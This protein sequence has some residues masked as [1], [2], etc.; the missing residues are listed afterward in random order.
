MNS[1]QW[2]RRVF[3]PVVWVVCL[4]PLA[5]LVY[6]LSLDLGA[7]PVETITNFTG[8]WTL[9]LI[10]ATLAISPL[11]WLTGINQLV[12]YR[13]VLGLF[14]FF[15]GF[16]HF[17]TF[18][19]FDHQFDVAGMWEDVRLRPYITAGFVAFV[20]MIPLAMTSTNGWI[21]RI[22]GRNWN[23]LHRLIY[24][25]AIA[26]VLHYYWKVSIKLP[27]TNPRNY[28]ILVAVLLGWRIWRTFA[29]K[30]ASEV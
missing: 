3:K 1:T 5:Y 21:R 9:R 22:G 4:A 17:M 24:V 28:A 18:F 25:S 8:I 2:R 16:L 12:N 15:Y 10:V 14:A 6:S 26:A 30:R 11:R 29:R 7:N 27:P 19:F 23:L 20:L 13:R